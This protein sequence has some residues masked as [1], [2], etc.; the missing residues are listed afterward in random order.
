MGQNLEMC[1]AG[2]T[3]VRGYKLLLLVAAV[4][5]TLL[6][7]TDGFAW[8][9]PT[10]IAIYFPYCISPDIKILDLSDILLACEPI[11]IQEFDETAFIT[12]NIGYAALTNAGEFWSSAFLPLGATF[13]FENLFD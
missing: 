2:S 7:G 3:S 4:L 11:A 12:D 13:S 1:T 8:L 6:L 5:E 10:N 9:G